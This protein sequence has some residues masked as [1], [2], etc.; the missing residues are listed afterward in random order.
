MADNDTKTI[1]APDIETL[2]REMA[3][4][5][6]DVMDFLIN[7]EPEPGK[8]FSAEGLD[9]LFITMKVFIAARIK[10]RFDEREPTEAGPHRMSVKVQVGIDGESWDVGPEQRPWYTTL[11]GEARRKAMN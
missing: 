3:E 2:G 8:T 9:D 1:N 10:A 5:K 4:Q 7:R 6:S 11:D